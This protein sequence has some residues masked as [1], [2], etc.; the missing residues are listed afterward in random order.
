MS[1]VNL[2]FTPVEMEKGW[3]SILLA[4]VTLRPYLLWAIINILIFLERGRKGETEKKRTIDVRETRWSVASWVCFDQG[5]EP[6]TQVMCP[7]PSSAWDNTPANWATWPGHLLWAFRLTELLWVS[8][9]EDTQNRLDLLLGY[10]RRKGWV[11][12]GRHWL[13]PAS[14]GFF[15]YCLSHCTNSLSHHLLSQKHSM[16]WQLKSKPDNLVLW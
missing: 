11:S 13:C 3:G 6:T 1:Q 10:H 9:P 4:L 12:V 5:F 7:R 2:F 16:C 15:V 14:S 8:W